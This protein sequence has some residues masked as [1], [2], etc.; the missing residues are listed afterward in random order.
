MRPDPPA[1]VA[2]M[3]AALL[4]GCSDLAGLQR[5]AAPPTGLGGESRQ[6]PSLSGDGLLLASLVERG[7]RATV[8]L[9]ERRSG[10]VLPLRQ[11]Q[12]LTPHRSPSLSWNGRYLALVGQRGPRSLPVIVDRLNGRIHPL[13]LPGDRDVQRLSLAPDGLRLAVQVIQSGRLQVQVFDLRG[14]LEPDQPPGRLERGGGQG[15]GR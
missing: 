2:L 10:R 3:A 9:Q 11:L 1:L 12:P 13:P 7:G 14:L 4:S 5:R 6:D 15:E 8:L